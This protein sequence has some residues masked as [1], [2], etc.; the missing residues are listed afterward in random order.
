MQKQWQ[1][2]ADKLSSDEGR[3]SER[4]KG[5]LAREE[6]APTVRTLWIYSA[7]RR[8]VNKIPIKTPPA[9][10]KEKQKTKWE[11]NKENKHK[12]NAPSTK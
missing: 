6:F 5:E 9:E 3:E 4:E 1:E 7:M 8:T 12:S 2:N 11:K 10:K